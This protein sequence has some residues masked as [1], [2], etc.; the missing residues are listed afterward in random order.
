MTTIALANDRMDNRAGQA[1]EAAL[2]AGAGPF[3]WIGDEQALRA[4]AWRHGSR[5]LLVL[6]LAC[7]G[8]AVAHLALA[9]ETIVAQGAAHVA[10]VTMPVLLPAALRIIYWV[11]PA[12]TILALLLLYSWFK[13]QM[14]REVWAGIRLGGTALSYTG[15]WRE[16]LWPLLG[17]VI[18]LAL[19]FSFFSILKLYVIPRPSSGPSFKRLVV[20]VPLV[21]LLGLGAWR[22]RRFLLSRTALGGRSG[23]LAGSAH[24]FA[25]NHLL[26]LL[27][28]PLTLGWI[29]PW[30][31][32]AQQRRLIGGMTL[33]DL[34]FQCTAK[35]RPLLTRFAVVWAGVIGIYLAAVLSIGALM[36]PKIIAAKAAMVRP[37]FDTHD[38][39]ALL[40]IGCVALL[41]IAVL[42]AW[43]KAAVWLQIAAG[44]RLNGQPVRL[45]ATTAEIA[46]LHLGNG[47]LKLA[48][49]GTL[50]PLAELRT[51]RFLARHIRY[52]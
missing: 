21:Y 52:A 8:V 28:V 13:L 5:M 4:L 46:G 23:S 38:V 22:G 27:L 12:G 26:G 41:A 36:G 11:A 32:M 16:L 37:D 43:Y 51:A 42:L 50:G 34:P 2:R 7:L 17:L 10:P 31:Q 45:T 19:V 25:L 30:K 20:S 44:S 15:T 18:G 47:V 9:P 35:A 49:L 14:R 48:S 1:A 40:L 39:R 29:L 6:L 33:G 24:A 3:T